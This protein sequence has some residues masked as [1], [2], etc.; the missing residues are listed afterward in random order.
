MK[1]PILIVLALLLGTGTLAAQPSA[2]A[3]A[4]LYPEKWAEV[5]KYIYDSWPSFFETHPE[6]PKPYAYALNP[7]TLYYAD[8]YWINDALLRQGYVEQ[9]RNTL[10]CLIFSVDS[11]GFIPNAW[12]WGTSRSQ[13]P[14][15]AMM[16]RSYYERTNDKAWLRGAY[17]AVLKEYEFWTNENGN[18][19]EDHR[20]L[21]PGLQRYGEHGTR[22]ELI[23]FYDRVLGVRFKA[24]KD[25]P[26]ELKCS[27][28]AQRLAECESMDF[29]PRYYGHCLDFIP[30]DLNANLYQYEK[31]LGFFEQELG[32]KSQ[33][34][35]TERAASRYELINRYLWNEKRGMYMD[36][37]FVAGR[38]THIVCIMA[39][40]MMCYDLVPAERMERFR[41]NI[42]EALEVKSGLTICGESDEDMAYQFGRTGIWGSAQFV[43]MNGLDKAGFKEDA[44][45]LAMKYLNMVTKNYVDPYPSEYIPFKKTQLE[46][47]PYGRLWEKFTYEGDINDNEY[48]CSPILGFT[49]AP[50]LLALDI[51][52]K[53]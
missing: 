24:P 33:Y 48:Y 25:V 6:L 50:Y 42:L 23:E 32:L 29:T 37:D 35:W 21:V 18:L 13:L 43:A 46:K 45:R 19:I 20:T 22:E 4:P 51:I 36:Y 52:R 14:Y 10:D 47:R 12:G 11:L 2:P 44:R 27:V 17:E 9:A 31:N 15:L 53:P 5:E 49:A 8:Q 39:F 30:T 7:G 16:V 1:N 28:A 26:D 40:S 38:H 34:N 3:P 41:D